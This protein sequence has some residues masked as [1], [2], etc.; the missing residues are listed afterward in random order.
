MNKEK[1]SYIEETGILFEQLGMT[2]MA[3][4]IF[5]LLIVSDQNT[6][7]FN[8]IQEVLNASKGSISGTTK[9]LIAVGFIEPVSLSGDRKTYFRISK[10]RAGTIL[11]ARLSLFYK[12]SDVIDKGNALKEKEDEISDWLREISA[13]Y[14]WLGGAVDELIIRWEVVKDTIM[15]NQA[16]DHEKSEK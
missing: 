14:K 5:G 2:R 12:F 4:R 13:F 6:V 11:K 7:S 10:M 3:G 15:E 16:K 8:H 9:Q 1:L